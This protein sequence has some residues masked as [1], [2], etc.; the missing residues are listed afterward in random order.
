LV[1]KNQKASMQ[2]PTDG[3]NI[4]TKTTGISPSKHVEG[5]VVDEGGTERTIFTLT[6]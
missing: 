4:Y 5:Y 1:L 3:I 2:I 6:T